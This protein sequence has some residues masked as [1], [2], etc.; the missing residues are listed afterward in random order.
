MHTHTRPHARRHVINAYTDC[1][2][3][4]CNSLPE[5]NEMTAIDPGPQE[6]SVGAAV[7]AALGDAVGLSLG[8][9]VTVTHDDAFVTFA[10][11]S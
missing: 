6:Y 11:I 3:P 5:S 2:W 8:A 9:S 4:R 7:G 1:I 10:K